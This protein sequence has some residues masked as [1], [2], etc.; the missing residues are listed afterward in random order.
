[1]G[2]LDKLKNIFNKTEEKE[3]EYR[4]YINKA[5]QY[6]EY[7]DYEEAVEFY[8]KALN[9]KSENANDWY[10]LALSYYNL[11]DYN[12][13]LNALK[14]AISLSKNHN[15]FYLK[16]LI[17]Y[18]M[19]ELNK[20]YDCLLKASDKIKKSEIYEMLGDICLK[21]KKYETALNYYLKAYKL[22]ENNTNALINAAKLY[23]LLGDVENAYT[24]FKQLLN[25]N[26]D[27]EYVEIAKSLEKII[28]NIDNNIVE[29]L[30]LGIRHLENK[31]YIS[32]LK[33]FNKVLEID[34]NNDVAYYYKSI[35]LEI[36]EEHLKGLSSIENALYEFER[37]LY[38]AKKGDLLNKLDKNDAVDAY[39]K[40]I[41]I[42]Q[43]PYAYFGLGTYHYKHKNYEEA[44]EL[45]DKI[46][47]LYLGNIPENEANLFTIYSLIGKGDITGVLKYYE[48]AMIYVSKILNWN[49]EN[50]NWLK[51]AGYIS[52]KLKKYNA[53]YDYYMNAYRLD[54]Q[55]IEVLK[56]L[57][58]INEEMG[59]Y[60]EA[61]SMAKK[62]LKITND[63]SVK[64]IIPKL[65][66][67]EP[68]DLEITSPILNPPAI[69]YKINTITYYLAMIY[70]YLF[71][72]PIGSYFYIMYV[73]NLDDLNTLE[74]EQR[75]KIE[76][77]L[78]YLKKALPS[79][80]YK[81]CQSPKDYTPSEEVISFCKNELVSLFGYII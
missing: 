34:E 58:V 17:H 41:E 60:E 31:D 35:V 78:E 44:S 42:Y 66:N 9:I 15:F 4:E 64:E 22:N 45:F 62:L 38:Y 81:F 46:L 36:F 2:I 80:M 74:E 23:L 77:V 13:A 70:K 5:N 12:S 49:S 16:G 53:A 56:A 76:R 57:I 63:E 30:T 68:I 51:V 21:N 19:G 48:Q 29:Y 59:N 73:E 6:F 10:N 1:M 39:K 7:G 69:Y 14:N 24:L 18:K 32:S 54:S 47:E 33:C 61:F 50:V 55:D 8:L 67:R 40:S 71:K 43:N 37:C 75:K 65:M 25:K 28:K 27:G 52:Y 26:V 20:A 3:E 11:G 79:E 72:N